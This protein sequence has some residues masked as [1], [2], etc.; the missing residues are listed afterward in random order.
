VCRYL[1]DGEG[2]WGSPGVPT[3]DAFLG[4]LDSGVF[5]FHHVS[6]TTT[7]GWLQGMK[8]TYRADIMEFLPEREPDEGS[9]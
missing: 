3:I 1:R 6:D 5:F 8:E 2:G 9:D 7:A 4:L